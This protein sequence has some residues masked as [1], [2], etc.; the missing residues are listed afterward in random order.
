M[1]RVKDITRALKLHDACL[2]A[3]ET[4]PGRIDVY[5][6]SRFG[7]HLPHLVMSLTDTWTPQGKP[8]PWG[9]DVILNRLRA[10]DLWRDDT[11]VDAWI[12]EHDKIEEGRARDR[13]N[14]IESFL[15]E[16]R[17][18]FHKATSDINTSLMDKKLS[19]RKPIYGHR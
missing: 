8:I 12:K 10:H 16:F 9:I 14:S 2:Y 15:Y 7:D 19:E 18:Q 11:F 13:R 6:K 5:R 3:Q 4:K 1:G 17:S